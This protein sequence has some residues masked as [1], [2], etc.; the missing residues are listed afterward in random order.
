MS[1]GGGDRARRLLCNV[2]GAILSVLAGQLCRFLV[3]NPRLTLG[4]TDAQVVAVYGSFN[5]WI[6]T[7]NYCAK[8]GDGWVCRIDLAPGKYTYRFLVD[9]I[10]MT[11]PANS[12]TEADGNG[13]VDSVIVVR[14]K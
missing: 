4:H 10:G 8:E 14:P 6:Q 12:A 5:D 1:Y 11:D 2:I 3:S 13:H 9:G 7:K